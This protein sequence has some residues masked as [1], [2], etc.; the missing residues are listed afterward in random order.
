M[1]LSAIQ[2]QLLLLSMES[3][4]VS[5]AESTASILQRSQGILMDIRGSLGS[6]RRSFTAMGF[7]L[8]YPD[9][10]LNRTVANA[11]YLN[12]A[13]VTV[14]VPVG[15]KIRW[16]DYVTT[17]EEAVELSLTITDDVLKPM[18]VYLAT[19]LTDPEK[20]KAVTL[21]VLE[22]EIKFNDVEIK[23]LK[24]TFKASFDQSNSPEVPYGQVFANKGEWPDVNDRLK[25][26]L[27]TAS[28]LDVSKFAEYVGEISECT[29]KLLIRMKNEP[30]VYKLNNINAETL[31]NRIFKAATEIEFVAAL[32]IMLNSAEQAM[33]D[34]VKK[35]KQNLA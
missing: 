8:Y 31:S 12:L 33:T 5:G 34:T 30:E 29:E 17:L 21:S 24:E 13:K 2:H 20:M 27:T 23:K 10:A 3:N 22:K 15:L 16:V 14:Y 26:V 35:L 4:G 18:K 6:A 19:L 32:K 1:E 11:N 9:S 7:K 28:K 25:K